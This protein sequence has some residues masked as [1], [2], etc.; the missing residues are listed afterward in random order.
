VYSATKAFVAGAV[1]SLIGDGLVDVALPVAHY[2]PEFA[3]NGK[4]AVTLE[5]VMLHTSGFPLAPMRAEVGATPAAR[6]DALARWRL[7]YEPG[8]KYHYHASSAHWVL[9]EVI[10]RVTGKDFRDVV[11]DRVTTPAGL[12]RVLGNVPHKAAELRVVGESASPEEMRATFGV[13]ALDVGEVT[14][15]ALLGFNDPATQAVGIPGGG[16]VMRACDLAMYYQAVLHN[17]GE[18]WNPVVLHDVKTNVRNSLPDV[19]TGVPANRTLGLIQAGADGKTNFRGMGRCVSPLAIGH[20]GAKGQ[21][22]W[23]DP[24]TGLSFGY[25]TNGLD[26]NEVREPRRTTALASLAAVCVT[27]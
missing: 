1:W 6:V 20:N 22:A 26:A 21:I 23:G 12:E 17:P 27:A 19:M 8:T 2:I 9:A 10:E 14:N 25:C 11:A 15:D 3:A 24:A 5:Q 16:G 13:A 4:E 18:M 7:N